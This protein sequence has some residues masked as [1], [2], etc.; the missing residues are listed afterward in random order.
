MQAFEPAVKRIAGKYAFSDN[1]CRRKRSFGQ[2]QKKLRE[3]I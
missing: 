2:V 3:D 1:R